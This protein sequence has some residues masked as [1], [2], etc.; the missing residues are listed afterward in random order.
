MDA[1]RHGHVPGGVTWERASWLALLVGVSLTPL[2]TGNLDPLGITV[3]FW[4]PV[5]L[6]KVAFLAI[7]SGLSAIALCISV[8]AEGRAVR[9]HWLAL[10]AAAALTWMAIVSA[11]AVRGDA[12]LFGRY[13]RND[14]IVAYA[15]YVALFT[16]AL[17]LVTDRRRL[18][19]LLRVA[20]VS[21]AFVAAYALVQYAGLDPVVRPEA[22]FGDRVFSTFGNPDMLAAYLVFPLVLSVGMALTEVKHW[23]V[24]AFWVA[25]CVQVLALVLTLVRGA[26][27]GVAV[28]F[29]VFVFAAVRQH[30]HPRRLD[31]AAIVLI[32]L[33]AGVTAG[34]AQP[35]AGMT[36]ASRVAAAFSDAG[37]DS[38]SARAAIYRAGA[39]AWAKRPLTGWGPGAFDEAFVSEA[40]A[41]YYTVAGTATIAD[42]AHSHPLH[43]LVTTG[44]PGALLTLA[45]LLGA[46][47]LSAA[48]VFDAEYS[49][50]RLGL[51]A[52]WSAL[53]GLMVALL[54][55]VSFPAVVAWAWLTAGVLVSVCAHTSE[56]PMRARTGVTLALAA[57]SLALVVVPALWAAAD[58]KVAVA[59]AGPPEQKAERLAA[60]IRMN[61]LPQYYYVQEGHA[62]AARVESLVNAQAPLGEIEY[63]IDEMLAGWQRAVE[64]DPEDLEARLQYSHAL[65]DAAQLL[66][67]H[68]YIGRSVEE[69]RAS[70][71]LAPRDPATLLQLSTVCQRAGYLDEARDASR[72]AVSMAP[73]FT[74]GWLQ[75]GLVEEARH[76]RMAA[77][78]AFTAALRLEPA[79]ASASESLA[80]VN[81]STTPSGPALN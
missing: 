13:M 14:G 29:V 25:A 1:Q 59:M 42:D 63:A 2:V 43:L 54:F 52:A 23:R 66:P 26:W 34:F 11:F 67:S 72:L 60:A 49:P 48:S 6:P 68:D 74:E 40:R 36:P 50:T 58:H 45:V 5:S 18:M 79:N 53:A 62:L 51:A 77:S 75:L 80:R 71:M 24:V 38:A 15:T 4:D 3:T 20:A 44:L 30:L 55:S 64:H 65:A 16:L 33:L 46:L 56:V 39:R 61:P 21:G 32:A 10:V 28:G 27:I 9:T 69:A 31:V 22:A 35:Q 81:G 78:D 17:E 41:D 76:D 19:T 37:T 47:L 73:A 57:A 70:A 12:A 8:L 7:L